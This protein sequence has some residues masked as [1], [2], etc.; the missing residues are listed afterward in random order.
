MLRFLILREAN[1]RVSEAGSPNLST[2]FH[3]STIRIDTSTTWK[4]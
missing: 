2:S 4:T 3:P 1:E